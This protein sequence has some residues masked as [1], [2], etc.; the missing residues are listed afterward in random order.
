MAT[1][2]NVEIEL[3]LTYLATEIPAATKGVAPIPL[4]DVYIPADREVHSHLRLR[5]KGGV[6]EITKRCS[7]KRMMH[8]HNVNILSLLSHSNPILWPALVVSAY[9]RT[10]T[11]WSLTDILL[12][13]MCSAVD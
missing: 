11:Q 6:H 4:L 9:R 3:E 12:R 2:R 7:S 13:W 10:A 8:L 1:P 5:Q